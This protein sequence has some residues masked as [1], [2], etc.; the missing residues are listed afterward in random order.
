MYESRAVRP[1]QRNWL[2]EDRAA[3]TGQIKRV[4]QVGCRALDHHGVTDSATAWGKLK[5]SQLLQ[6]FGVVRGHLFLAPFNQGFAVGNAIGEKGRI[7]VL[8]GQRRRVAVVRLFEQQDGRQ[9]LVVAGMVQ[10]VLQA[11]VGFFSVQGCELHGLA[12]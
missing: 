5:R 4:K 11:G 12:S 9:E 7:H 3:D 8:G 10:G 6:S 1:N 2:I